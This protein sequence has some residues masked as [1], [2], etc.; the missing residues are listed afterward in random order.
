MR[1]V[2]LAGVSLTVTACGMSAPTPVA[3]RPN[4]PTP[5]VLSLAEAPQAECTLWRE[6]AGQRQCLDGPAAAQAQPSRLA[7]PAPSA[8][9]RL[10]VTSQALD[11]PQATVSASTAPAAAPSPDS[12]LTG[13]NLFEEMRQIGMIKQQAA[14]P[15]ASA[16]AAAP[17][18]TATAVAQADAGALPGLPRLPN[19]NAPALPA[20]QATTAPVATTADLPDLP[21]AAPGVV[22]AAQAPAAGNLRAFADQTPAV[23]PAAA[24]N[25]APKVTSVVSQSWAPVEPPK[26]EA[27]RVQVAASTPGVQEIVGRAPVS[28][29]EK[30]DLPAVRG[31]TVVPLKI[32]QKA[33]DER[34]AVV[35]PDMPAKAQVAQAAPAL[36]ALPSL[37]PLPNAA[38]TS[39]TG[40]QPAM[41]SPAPVTAMPVPPPPALP[42]STAQATTAAPALPPVPSAPV[43]S[44]PVSSA[45]VSIAPAPKP[46]PAYTPAPPAT[47][48]PG[49]LAKAAPGKPVQAKPVAVAAKAGSGRF[50]VLQSFQERDHADRLA[51]R[52][53]NLDAKVASA[54][55]KGQTW[56]RVVVRDGAAERQKLAS[57]G[58]RGYWPTT[59]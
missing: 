14:T 40:S 44:A 52:H 37:P 42:K 32:S 25:G 17:A 47:P 45:P 41:A 55:V 12:V 24:R 35:V 54:T 8:A 18:P 51:S 19:M 56:Y 59:L 16:P 28:P 33:T 15:A 39:S 49:P 21:R 11:A 31:A 9:P 34:P 30:A 5:Y 23:A 53:R 48:K 7:A 13:S 4:P 36:P 26:S 46:V 22:T 27:T 10:A 29:V 20:A 43:S 3:Q 50:L 6:V 38:S 58:I 1:R 57:E 2:L